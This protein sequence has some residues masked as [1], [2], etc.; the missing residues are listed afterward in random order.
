MW[1]YSDNVPWAKLGKLRKWG[2]HMKTT[3]IIEKMFNDEQYCR[4]FGL[5]D[6]SGETFR[7]IRL[8]EK[9]VQKKQTVKSQLGTYWE[10]I[11]KWVSPYKTCVSSH[12]LTSQLIRN[13]GI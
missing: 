12:T 9:M 2:D 8:L 11:W 5:Y 13:E 4:K 3:P 6:W 1:Y 10:R 7:K